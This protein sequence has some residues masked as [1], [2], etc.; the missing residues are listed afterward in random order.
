MQE[1]IEGGTYIRKARTVPRK[2]GKK[3]K[4]TDA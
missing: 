1:A 3:G 4:H 2:E